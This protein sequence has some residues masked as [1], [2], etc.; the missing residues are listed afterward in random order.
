M[1]E[2]D[3]CRLLSGPAAISAQVVL[4]FMVLGSLLY[5]RQKEYPQ[6]PINVFCLD[7]SK[8]AFSSGAAHVCGMLIAIIAHFS[9]SDDSPSECAWYFVVFTADTSLG[10]ALAIGLHNA[11]LRCAR[12]WGDAGGKRSELAQAIAECGQYG[13]PVELWRW[14]AQMAVLLTARVLKYIALV[15][16]IVFSGHPTLLLFFVMVACPLGMNLIQA[17]IQDAFLKHKEGTGS[18]SSEYGRLL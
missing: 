4:L 14:A 12:R 6:R 5:K 3:E 16:D 7:I 8:Q 17:W 2:L 11:M 18:P 1:S 13:S 10:V 9:T 15:L